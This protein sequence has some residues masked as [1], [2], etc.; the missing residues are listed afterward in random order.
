MYWTGGKGGLNQHIFKVVPKTGYPKE[1]V[2][3]Q[4]S[5]Y[6][7]N[8][9]K[10]A[11]ARKTTMG[12]ITS[13]HMEQ[14]RIALPPAPV[15]QQFHAAIAATHERIIKCKKENRE[16]SQLRDWLLPMLMNGQA[17]VEDISEP[18]PSQVVDLSPSDSGFES[19]LQN[20]GLAARGTVDRQTYLNIYHAMDEDDK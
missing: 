15:L 8:F 16:L 17:K 13:D 6:I 10:M 1:F 3:H 2:Y 5:A 11:E 12:H 18:V 9:V 14:S 20:Q 4:L 7:I 19:W